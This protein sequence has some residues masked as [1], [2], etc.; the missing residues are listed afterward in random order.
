MAIF[1]S[2]VHSSPRHQFSKAPQSEIVLLK[3]LGVEGD[4]H[5]GTTVK[6]RSRVAKDPTQPNL[7]QVHLIHSELL[8]FL[9]QNGYPVSPGA[10]GENITTQGI[11]LLSLPVN[12]ELHIGRSAIVTVT[13]LRNPCAQIENYQAGLL[14]QVLEKK[15]DGTLIRKAGIMGIVTASGTVAPG[16]AVKVILPPAPHRALDWV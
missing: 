7:R 5:C 16:D 2:A 3:G 12:T 1:V 11:A 9:A 13:G 6:H 10:L 15:A 14:S 8:S 4:A